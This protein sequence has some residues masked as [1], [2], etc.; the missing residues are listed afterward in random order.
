MIKKCLFVSL[1]FF[2]STTI[3]AQEEAIPEAVWN[4]RTEFKA[5]EERIMRYIKELEENPTKDLERKSKANYIMRW[6]MSCPYTT[7]K[8]NDGYFVKILTDKNYKHA[9]FLAYSLVFGEVL[10]YLENPY[11]RDRTNAFRNGVYYSMNIYRK[12]KAFDSKTTCETLELFLKLEENNTLNS[13]I[14]LEN[15]K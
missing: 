12:V 1:L 2:F 11:D 14:F 10:Y 7:V 5:S 3:F 6:V 15:S 9:E 13:F 8:L 4:S